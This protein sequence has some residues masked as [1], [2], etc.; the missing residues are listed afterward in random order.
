MLLKIALNSRIKA[1]HFILIIALLYWSPHF[2]VFP[3]LTEPAASFLLQ[4]LL[5]LQVQ[6]LVSFF[7]WLPIPLIASFFLI[8]EFSNVAVGPL[9]CMMRLDTPN[10]NKFEHYIL[11][12]T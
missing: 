9:I 4:F 8:L 10:Y 7:L 5:H 3:C 12:G 2:K 1:H 11:L 6:K